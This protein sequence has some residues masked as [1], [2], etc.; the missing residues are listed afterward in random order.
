MSEGPGYIAEAQTEAK[1]EDTE[2]VE[3]W[4]KKLE[5]GPAEPELESHLVE[6][7]PD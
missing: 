6:I 2:P 1:Q 5:E 3:T 7:K 4:E